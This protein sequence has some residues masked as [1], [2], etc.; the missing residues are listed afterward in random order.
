MQ[1]PSRRNTI[2]SWIVVAAFLALWLFHGWRV[3]DHARSYDFLC[4]YSAAY[5]ISHGR[6]ADLYDPAVQFAVQKRLAP[7]SVE[8]GPS[9]RPPLPFN[10]PPFYALL[11]APL[12]WLPFRAAFV[13][14]ILL[15]IGVFVACLTWAWQR[16]G[17]PALVF[18]CMSMP[19]AM[20]IANAQDS[21]LFLAILIASYRL[22]EKG[23]EWIGGIV[24]GLLLVKFHLAPLWP[25]ALIL[26]RRWKMLAGFV[27]TGAVAAG[28]SLAMIGVDGARAYVALLQNRDLA[29]LPPGPEY[30]ISVQGL[31][32][33]LGI[34]SMLALAAVVTAILALFLVSLWHAPLWRAYAATTAA[35]LLLVP[36]VHMYDATMLLLGLW[37]AMFCT[38]FRPTRI[39]AIWL[40]TPLPFSFMAAGKPWAAASALSLLALVAVLAAEASTNCAK[41]SRPFPASPNISSPSPG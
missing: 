30:M 39:V 10:R 22:A 7:S 6:M 29:W 13:C 8:L 14:W 15:Q 37:L 38:D 11:L 35:S 19:A 34:T 31:A 40:F 12:G 3:R 20:G 36:H 17:T 24:L 41:R 18:G 23:M 4:T 1:T 21:V 16:F 33:N 32:A 9:N 27:A 26:Q 25:I 28:I 2:A 5:V